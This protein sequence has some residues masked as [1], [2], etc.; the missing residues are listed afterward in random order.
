LL[1]DKH[2]LMPYKPRRGGEVVVFVG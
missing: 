2:N 1:A